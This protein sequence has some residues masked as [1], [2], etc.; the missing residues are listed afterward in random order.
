[1][2]QYRHTPQGEG[3]KAQS[4]RKTEGDPAV[5]KYNNLKSLFTALTT[6]HKYQKLK[7]IYLERE[8]Q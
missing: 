2:L 6:Q 8:R 4:T 1:M 3:F 5:P 7:Y